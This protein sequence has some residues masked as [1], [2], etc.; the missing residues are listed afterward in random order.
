MERESS[1][2]LKHR[3]IHFCPFH[4]DQQQ[5]HSA[6]LLLSDVEGI[7]LLRPQHAHLLHVSYD[8]TLLNL[9]LIEDVLI[10]L[11][12]HLDNSLIVKLKRA[13]YYYTEEVER[14]NLGIDECGCADRQV[15]IN[16]YS[17]LRH[18]CRDE[19]PEHWRNYL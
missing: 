12:F 2:L 4:P 10:D 8:I 14:A 7:R 6:S 17:K 13:L 15:F 16:R 1:E 11:G 3:Q 19:R 18:G 9:N 5:A